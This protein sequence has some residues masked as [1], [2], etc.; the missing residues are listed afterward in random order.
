MGFHPSVSGLCVL[1][2]LTGESAAAINFG[3]VAKFTPP[4]ESLA[5]RSRS[6]FG[7]GG[8][9]FSENKINTSAGVVLQSREREV[10]LLKR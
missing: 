1:S 2:I 5:P 6:I 4:G 3:A 8:G 9:K 7:V 10:V